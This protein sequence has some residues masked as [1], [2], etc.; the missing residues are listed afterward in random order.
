LSLDAG[1][2]FQIYFDTQLV[3]TLLSSTIK[4]LASANY[5]GGSLYDYPSIIT[6]GQVSHSIDSL[7][8][9]IQSVISSS[10]VSFGFRDVSLIFLN[11]STTP[12]TSACSYSNTV[13]SVS[14]CLCSSGEYKSSSAIGCSSC[15]SACESCLGSSQDQCTSCK[16]G[17]SFYNQE[18][19]QCDSSCEQCTGA[20]ESDCITCPSG[21]YLYW[22]G[23]CLSS[24]DP[25]L[26]STVDGEENLCN[27]P[28]NISEYWN[29]DDE[30]CQEICDSPLVILTQG[31]LKTCNQ[32]CSDGEYYY[33]NETCHSSCDSPL[34]TST[35]NSVLSCEL[36]CEIGEYYY[37]NDTCQ[38]SCDP[39]FVS[40]SNGDLGICYLPCGA[41]EFLDWKMIC[42]PSCDPPLV[43]SVKQDISVCSL[44]CETGYWLYSNSSCLRDCPD[45]FKSSLQGE[46]LMCEGPCPA[47]QYYFLEDSSCQ[48]ECESPLIS[49]EIGV[50]LICE[51]GPESK[52]NNN[53]TANEEDSS[54][55]SGLETL[56]QA[57]SG[58]AVVATLLNFQDP[59]S[60]F[61]LILS[62]LLI[63][64]KY[65][66]VD[67][68]Q[69]VEN[70]FDAEEDF[71][72]PALS[73]GYNIPNI[74]S[75]ELPKWPIPAIFEKRGLH[76]SFLVNDWDQLTMLGISSLAFLLYYPLR[77]LAEKIKNEFIKRQIEKLE[78]LVK[79][80]LFLMFFFTN[81]AE[82]TL[83]SVLEFRTFRAT[84]FFAVLSLLVA[85]VL[86]VLGG[87]Y[88]IKLLKTSLILIKEERSEKKEEEEDNRF[89]AYEIFYEAY[90]GK[91]IWTQ[92]YLFFFTVR[93]ILC[94]GI[95]AGL[96]EYPLLQ[97]II[98]TGLSGIMLMYALIVRPTKEI[99]H[100]VEVV[101][102]ELIILVVNICVIVFAVL[103]SQ[104]KE[105][106]TQ[107]NN[108]GRA[109]VLCNTTVRIL[110]SIFVLLSF[111]INLIQ[112]YLL[113]EKSSPYMSLRRLL[114]LRFKHQ[115][116]SPDSPYHPKV[117]K[118][119]KKSS[120][121]AFKSILKRLLSLKFKHQKVLPHNE[122]GHIFG[123]TKLLKAK[124]KPE[125]TVIT[126][127]KQSST[128]KSVYFTTTK[129]ENV[130]TES[131]GLVLSPSEEK[132][133]PGVPGLEARPSSYLRQFDIAPLYYR[134][135]GNGPITSS[136]VF[137]QTN[138]NGEG[139]NEP[140][141]MTSCASFSEISPSIMIEAGQEKSPEIG[142]EFH[143]K[144]PIGQNSARRSPRT[145]GKRFQ[146]RLSE[147]Q[148]EMFEIRSEEMGADS[149]G[150]SRRSL[151]NLMMVKR[152]SGSNTKK[153]TLEVIHENPKKSSFE[154]IPDSGAI[155]SI[156]IHGPS[157]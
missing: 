139:S 156:R 98:L 122:T 100:T 47:G 93:I 50:L 116:V 123:K 43:S 148:S 15:D 73:L 112:K 95:I 41:S 16:Q 7:T 105:L 146:F 124:A 9:K 121:Q 6:T 131:L 35:N 118:Y 81:Y 144:L 141:G 125:S 71:F 22:N 140:N 108:L 27:L 114:S 33:W 44:L 87:Y 155:S 58:I 136:I 13:L 135:K 26:V 52:E 77:W 48:M 38:S 28:C 10:S 78:S 147:V 40:L 133:I 129:V 46:V 106:E 119:K 110:S 45:P 60:L 127:N 23:T 99:L 91:N 57:T 157:G 75:K 130:T 120:F 21:S 82:I 84:S 83:Y 102:F 56:G 3:S 103:D 31:D 154:E 117:L 96:Y 151:E 2:L 132:D 149:K 150:L 64:I 61:V 54:S 67:Y 85:I 113:R 80:N 18:C 79:W 4:G 63:Y 134:P 66:Q 145:L 32:P 51:K 94:Y 107:R 1:Y 55:S 5:C 97:S 109:V 59:T 70:L 69:N 111:L 14:S 19:S 8:F 34:V 17:Y 36:P 25:P 68:P 90:K 152:N 29:N 137:S 20:S 62:D 53:S 72:S 92:G 126:I 115:K 142:M 30:I 24:C 101:V 86:I 153:E 11:A 12:A 39:P 88:L 49:K 76:S 74:L 65:I 143:L 42:Q 138:N 128:M 37:F 89:K 104:G